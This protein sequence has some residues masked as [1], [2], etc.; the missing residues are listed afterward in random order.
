MELGFNRAFST[1]VDS[2]VTT[3]FAAVVLFFLGTGPIKGF[4]VTLTVGIIISMFTAITVTKYLLITLIRTN[5]IKDPRF[6]GK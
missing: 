6:F 1:I 4:A 3:L 2:N 5:L